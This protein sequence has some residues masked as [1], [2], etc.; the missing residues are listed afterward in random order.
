MMR[1]LSRIV[2]VVS[3]LVGACAV[4]AAQ[5]AK[6]PVIY[7]ATL[8]ADQSVL[9]VSGMMSGMMGSMMNG[10]GAWVLAMALMLFVIIAIA[11]MALA[12][13]ALRRR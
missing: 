8:S 11:G 10:A 6:S 5:D 1:S 4:A 3:V 13:A 7:S 9:F 12:A 2:V